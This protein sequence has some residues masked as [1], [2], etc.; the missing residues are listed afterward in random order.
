MLAVSRVR[1]EL[2]ATQPVALPAHPAAVLYATVAAAFA[3]SRRGISAVPDGVLVD[4][5]EIARLTL[6][7]DDVYHFGITF[8]GLAPPAVSELACH[9]S[10]G[11]TKLGKAKIPN[12]P[13]FGGNFRMRA[14]V[15]LVLNQARVPRH[16]A[17]AV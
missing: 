8:L 14:V 2:V 11:L 12:R 5:V 15:D 9:L 13:V 17:S 7:S 3:R 10:D 6:R 4:P 16:F 1:V